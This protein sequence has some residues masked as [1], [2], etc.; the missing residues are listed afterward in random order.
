[1]EQLRLRGWFV[2]STHGS[3]YQSGFPDLYACHAQYGAKWIEVKQR[4][5]YKFTPAQVETFGKLITNHIGIWVL[6]DWSSD[7]LD[8]IH[9]A[10]NAWAYMMGA[11]I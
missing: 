2:K 1:M 8:K 5:G 3:L 4:T 7:E 11:G 10:P 9:G 6:V